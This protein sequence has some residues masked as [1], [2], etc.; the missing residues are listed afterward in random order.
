MGQ[1][2]TTLAGTRFGHLRNRLGHYPAGVLGILH[3]VGDD[4]VH[5]DRV[6]VGVPA[7]VIRHHGDSHVADLGFARQLRLLQVRHADDVHTPTAVDVGFRLGGKRRTFHA[8]VRPAQL[9]IDA[10]RA[11]GV[12]QH[13]AHLRADRVREADVRHQALAEER[14]DAP[15]GA[16]EELVGEDEILRSMLFL[17]RAHR[18]QRNDALH[19]QRLHAVDIGPEIEL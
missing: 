2:R 10:G 16:V 9:H 15:A 11:A 13:A 1:R 7:I 18:A 3:Q 5:R 8:E 12:L 4:V 6:M 19:A 14:G 17:E